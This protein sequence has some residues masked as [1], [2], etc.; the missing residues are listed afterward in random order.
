[1]GVTYYKRFRMEI[2]LS[3]SRLPAAELPPEYEFVA[4]NAVLLERHAEA[5][6]ESFRAELDSDVFPCLG[7][8]SG[9]R[10]LMSEIVQRATFVPQAT[11]LI[12]WTGD[13]RHEDCGTIQGVVQ[14]GH[15][16]AVQNVGVPPH[17]RGLGLGRALVLKA[18]DGF[19]RAGVSRVYLEV[20]ARNLAAVALYRSIGFRLA[21]TTYRAVERGTEAYAVL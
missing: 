15:W 17:F 3:R 8:L 12:S 1:M 7:D 16:G 6:F 11:W 19:R 18:L 20:T 10:H 5:K 21:R 2:D 14:G 13:G 9:C 4:W